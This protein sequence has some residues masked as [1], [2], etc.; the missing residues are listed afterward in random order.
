VLATAVQSSYGGMAI[1]VL[2]SGIGL[3]GV[4]CTLALPETRH[5]SLQPGGAAGPLSAGRRL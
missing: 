5:R 4:G 1:G 3:L 2:L